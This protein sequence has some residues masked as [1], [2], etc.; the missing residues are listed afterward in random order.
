LPDFGG[1]FFSRKFLPPDRPGLERS[2]IVPFSIRRPSAS[3]A[4]S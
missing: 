1:Y 4:K 3:L 2:V